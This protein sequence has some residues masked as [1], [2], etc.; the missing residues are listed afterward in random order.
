MAMNLQFEGRWRWALAIA[1]AAG[2]MV[3]TVLP[4]GWHLVVRSVIVGAVT[5]AILFVAAG[6]RS[7]LED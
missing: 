3:G 6:I 7:L 1:V 4:D 2:L 5:A